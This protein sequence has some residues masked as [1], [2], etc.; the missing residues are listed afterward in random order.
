MRRVGWGLALCLAV[1]GAVSAQTARHQVLIDRDV[2]AATGCTVVAPGGVV[3]GIEL[4][5]RAEV[6]GTTV[7]SV[8]RADCAAGTLG[9][10]TAVGGPHAVGLNVGV[11][12]ATDDAPA[13][14]T[15]RLKND[16]PSGAPVESGA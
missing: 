3:N 15:P 4:V 16:C 8:S 14:W 13:N 10:F 11:A 5:L 12:V 7:T 2:N 1:V 6:T 9:A